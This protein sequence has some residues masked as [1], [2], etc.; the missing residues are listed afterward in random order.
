MDGFR[1]RNAVKTTSDS[2]FTIDLL[3][4]KNERYDWLVLSSLSIEKS[5]YV[6]QTA[7]LLTIE[8]TTAGGT[9]E[10]TLVFPEGN[11]D[12]PGVATR[13][14]TEFSDYTTTSPTATGFADRSKFTI[15]H[16][17]ETALTA[18]SR[19]K[20]ASDELADMF[21]LPLHNTWYSFGT[22]PDTF[23]SINAINFQ[24]HG[25]ISIICSGAD[26]RQNRLATIDMAS[27]DYGS[28]LVYAPIDIFLDSVRMDTMDITTAFH[29]SLVDADDGITQIQLNGVKFRMELTLWSMTSNVSLNI[30]NAVRFWYVQ[31][32]D[33]ARSAQRQMASIPDSG[34]ETQLKTKRLKV[35]SDEKE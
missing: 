30:L 26:A 29:M 3:H 12:A 10:L 8:H 25:A 31:E 23:E 9:V 11:Y 19:I 21:G 13:M 1:Y 27:I 24:K 2:K 18:P 20:V 15:T 22:A 28:I 5:Y 33:K 14:N 34:E 4:D 16:T 17:G 35:D 7:S 6:I 32:R